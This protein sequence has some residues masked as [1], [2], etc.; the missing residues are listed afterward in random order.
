MALSPERA[1]RHVTEWSERLRS[2]PRGSLW[3]A[4][5]FHAAHAT[6]AVAMLRSERLS[7]RSRIGT[8]AHDVAN[9]GALHNNPR[10]HDYARLYFR[11][12]NVFHLKTEGVKCI[13]DPNRDRHHMSVPVLLAFDALSVLTLQGAG[14]SQASSPRSARSGTTSGSSTAY[15]SISCSTT[16]RSIP[17]RWRGCKTAG[18]RRS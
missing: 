16:A 8:V 11:P 6:T 13:G 12:R 5:L 10:A 15:P 4:Y 1:T 3:P 2:S 17:S 9:Q 14:F 7:S 18:W